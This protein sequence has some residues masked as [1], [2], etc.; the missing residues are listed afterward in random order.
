MKKMDK[1]NE[2]IKIA[3]EAANKQKMN[4]DSFAADAQQTEKI[5]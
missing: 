2:I 4:L 3:T 1:V 5:S